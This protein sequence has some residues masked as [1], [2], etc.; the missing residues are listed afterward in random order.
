[1]LS[2]AAGRVAQV[3]VFTRPSGAGLTIERGPRPSADP[4]TWEQR[5]QGGDGGFQAG[6]VQG[7][8]HGAV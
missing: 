1:M 4:V 6:E 2:E 7:V 8:H 3:S 5:G